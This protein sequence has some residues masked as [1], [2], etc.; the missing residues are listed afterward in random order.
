MADGDAEKTHL[1]AFT[2]TIS[3]AESMIDADG[4]GDANDIQIA[5]GR[6]RQSR[7]FTEGEALTI[8]LLVE[9]G[10]KV[11]LLSPDVVAADVVDPLVQIKSG[12]AFGPDDVLIRAFDKVGRPLGT[13]G[14]DKVSTLTE[15]ILAFRDA[16]KPGQQFLLRIDEMELEEA[17]KTVLRADSD[18]GIEIYS[19]V[20][21]I[22]RGA[23]A[24]P[25]ATASAADPTGIR[26]ADLAHATSHIGP[27]AH[28]HLNAAS[29]VF[30]VD[31]VDDD[32]GD[33]QYA[34]LTSSSAARDVAANGLPPNDAV[35][36]RGSG[37]PGVVS[38]MRIVN[39]IGFIE[40][41][42]FDVRIILTEDPKRRSHGG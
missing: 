5:T 40:T 26:K 13:L 12:P 39:R 29:N 16:E 19:L 25:G 11:E 42:S 31:L 17:Y 24:D 1:D 7:E 38:I 10:A 37:T 36:N 30:R 3:A 41:G 23:G 8:T 27:G 14:L 2:V 4:R 28:Q 15:S 35:A 32:Q 18:A 22:A 21:Y 6:D 33:A 34:Q 9:F 20:F